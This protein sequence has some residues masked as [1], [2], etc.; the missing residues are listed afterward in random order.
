MKQ[1]IIS[2]IL[3]CL[4][5][6]PILIMGGVIFNMVML[7]LGMIGLHE[8]IKVRENKKEFP[9]FVKSISYIYLAV[10]I[11][12]S[13]GNNDIVFNFDYRLLSLTILCTAI[14]LVLYHDHNK[15]NINDV[16]Y[17]LVSTILIGLSFNLIIIIRNIDLLIIIYLIIITVMTDTY[18]YIGGVLS[19][20]NKLVPSIS[21]NKTVEGLVVGTVFGTLIACV[22]YY[23]KINDSININQLIYITLFLSIIGQFGDL[24]FSSIKRYYG[25][26]DFSN[27]MPGHGGLLD[28]IDS[29]I[30][31]L[32]GYLFFIHMI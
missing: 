23:I 16:M 9:L 20:R 11:I 19:G 18:A 31:V 21:P 5:L 8:L 14:P 30:F 28:R 26:K 17:L 25:I 10:L 22:F 3:A 32:I 7:T 15:Y 12:E 29:I 24:V 1:R 4:I 2:A 6:I 27:I 13:F